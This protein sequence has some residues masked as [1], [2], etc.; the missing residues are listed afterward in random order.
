MPKTTD[1]TYHML[2]VEDDA[3]IL[4]GLEDYFELD[5]YVV[6][7]AEDGDEAL[8]KMKDMDKC[9]VVLLDVMLPKKDGFEVLE[10]SQEMGFRDRK[11]VV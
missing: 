4:M 9:D 5:D 10:A 7:T 8:Q 11:S 3:N 2:I 6:E 1:R